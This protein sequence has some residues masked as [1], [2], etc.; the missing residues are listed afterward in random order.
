LLIEHCA[1]Y[2]LKAV[3][4]L[5]NHHRK[6]AIHYLALLGLHHGKLMNFYPPSLEKEFVSS[7]LNWEKRTNFT[8]HDRQWRPVDAES[9][10]LNHMVVR[11]LEEWGAFLDTQLFYDAIIHFRG[12]PEAVVR[13]I[14][15]RYDGHRLGRQP[16]H[17]LNDRTAFKITALTSH[18]RSY[19][20]HLS[21]FL[22]N[23]S[24]HHIHWINFDH[25]DII[26]QTISRD[27]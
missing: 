27:S 6:Q 11:L 10:W 15:V 20:R 14:E 3:A 19:G 23:T 9:R 8:I 16:A 12:G 5:H 25:H 18:M 2:E 24:L 4:S 17:L 13:P 22:S 7:N 21:R 1:I 26:F